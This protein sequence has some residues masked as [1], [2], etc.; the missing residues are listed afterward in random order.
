VLEYWVLKS[1][2][3]KLFYILVDNHGGSINPKGAEN[4]KVLYNKKIYFAYSAS[5]GLAVSLS[6]F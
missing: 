4:P 2:I 6:L 3:G 1:Q 5:L